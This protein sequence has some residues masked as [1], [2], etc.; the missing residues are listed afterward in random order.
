MTWIAVSIIIGIFLLIGAISGIA[1]V[2]NECYIKAFKIR[3]EQLER[4]VTILESKDRFNKPP[5]NET[6]TIY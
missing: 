5:S 4:R 1:A 2:I 3:I 6:Y